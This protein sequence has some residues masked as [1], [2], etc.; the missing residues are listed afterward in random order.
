MASRDE[1]SIDVGL[2]P[3][4]EDTGNTIATGFGQLGE[5][6]PRPVPDLEFRFPSFAPDNSLVDGTPSGEVQLRVPR[7]IEHVG[8]PAPTI[9][10]VPGARTQENDDL[11]GQIAS[12]QAALKV[13]SAR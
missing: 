7:R 12:M 11:I 2:S 6:R 5:G 3:G 10:T 1:P 8:E 13:I 4:R 9:L